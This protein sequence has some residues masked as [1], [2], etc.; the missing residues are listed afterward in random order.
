MSRRRSAS[1]QSLWHGPIQW[2][3]KDLSDWVGNRSAESLPFW[4]TWVCGGAC[5]LALTAERWH[6]S[7]SVL[8]AATR[9][10]S[11]AAALLGF[12]LGLAVGKRKPMRL[13][14]TLFFLLV[15]WAVFGAAMLLDVGVL[16]SPISDTAFFGIPMARDLAQSMN[17]V[18]FIGLVFLVHALAL[19]PMGQVAGGLLARVSPLQGVGFALT[20]L[21][22]GGLLFAACA[23]WGA[24]MAVVFAVALSV[25]C[26]VLGSAYCLSGGLAAIALLF[27]VFS[28]GDGRAFT[29]AV[30]SAYQDLTVRA[31]RGE[32]RVDVS[33]QGLP[34]QSA[35]EFANGQLGAMR[36]DM[37]FQFS[38]EVADVLVIGAG[39]GN[40]VAAALRRGAGRV[41]AIESDP[42]VLELGE[43]FHPEKPYDDKR[44]HFT[45]TDPRLFLRKLDRRYDLIVFA[46]SGSPFAKAAFAPLRLNTLSLTDH[47]LRLARALLKEKGL[48]AVTFANLS[49]TQ[50]KRVY[51]TLSQV[52]EGRA[53]IALQ[54]GYD[55]GVVFFAGNGLETAAATA[56]TLPVLTAH[57]SQGGE[58]MTDDKPL[59][60]RT[61]SGYPWSSAG[62]SFALLVLS[63]VL[64][65]ALLPTERR[66]GKAVS[67]WAVFFAGA[68]VTLLETKAIA[69]WL[70]EFGNTAPMAAAAFAASCALALIANVVIAR[71]RK[72]P[73]VGA[74]FV[75]AGCLLTQCLFPHWAAIAGGLFGLFCILCLQLREQ[76]QTAKGLG[77]LLLGSMVAGLL[78]FHLLLAGSGVLC[79]IAL[80]FAACAAAVQFWRPRSRAARATGK[81][82]LR[83]VG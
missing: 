15:Q 25:L 60:D 7:L 37:P 10:P 64:S 55:S 29:T 27:A 66:T 47:T 76:E 57:Y 28:G 44:V 79:W 46:S 62:F 24:A 16:T 58:P 67:A 31:G 52:F 73:K 53:P 82:A 33:S 69:S 50:G 22:S 3:Q 30:A 45:S 18:C 83:K 72:F 49:D 68:S 65:W 14:H 75:A 43:A 4:I 80:G 6:A 8:F 81:V 39:L 11:I 78:E 35:F 13:P 12:G 59:L 56:N 19:V 77:A 38:R 54:S 61:T 36:F 5:F 41:D 42:V 63:M 2:F 71:I 70:T 74:W 32:S 23:H 1:L 48:L 21:M 51:Q 17:A 40:E 9:F 34:L 20:G 26:A